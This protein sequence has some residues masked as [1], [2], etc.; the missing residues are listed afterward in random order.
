MTLTITTCRVARTWDLP[1]GTNSCWQ[2][3]VWWAGRYM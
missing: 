3:K 1:K 2:C